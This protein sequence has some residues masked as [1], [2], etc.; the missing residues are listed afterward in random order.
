MTLAEAAARFAAAGVASTADD[1]LAS[2]KRCKPARAPIYRDGD[3]YALDPHDDEVSFWLFRLGLRPARVAPLRDA[4]R[5]SAPLPSPDQPLTVAALNEAWREG[6][7]NAWSAQRVA[8]AVLDAHDRHVVRRSHRVRVGAE[9]VEPLRPESAQFWRSGAIVSPRRRAVGADSGTRGRAVDARGGAQP[10]QRH[11]ALGGD[12]SRPSAMEAHRQRIERERDRP[13][14]A[15]G[16][17]AACA[18]PCVS[19]ERDREPSH[20]SMLGHAR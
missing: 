13:R 9:P 3:H 11:A 2:L 8:V 7:P 6:V 5:R 10:R 1:A 12:A 19:C 15:V 4:S 16:C 18:R 20:S 17:D 14:S